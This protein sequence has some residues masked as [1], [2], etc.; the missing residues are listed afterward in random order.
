K[1]L[2]EGGVADARRTRVLDE[3]QRI[4]LAEDRK[5]TGTKKLE[6]NTG[7]CRDVPGD[8]HRIIVRPRTVWAGDKNHPRGH[9]YSQFTRAET[10]AAVS[11]A[12]FCAVRISSS[13]SRTGLPCSVGTSCTPKPDLRTSSRHCSHALKLDP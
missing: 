13:R 1:D 2:V 12:P 10:A 8:E 6:C 9:C 3:R 5:V 11:M 4:P 7:H